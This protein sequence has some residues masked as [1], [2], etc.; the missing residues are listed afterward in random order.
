MTVGLGDGEDSQERVSV[1]LLDV[2]I[3]DQG[4]RD[5]VRLRKESLS[6]CCTPDFEPD[7]EAVRPS[8]KRF[9]RRSFF[10]QGREAITREFLSF[11]CTSEF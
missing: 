3:Q 2:S 8:G 5:A 1:F 11:C 10:R 6:F 4:G 9:C 7:R